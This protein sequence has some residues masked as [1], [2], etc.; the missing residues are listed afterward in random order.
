MK[1]DEDKSMSNTICKTIV[2]DLK[3]IYHMLGIDGQNT[4]KRVS[5]PGFWCD[6]KT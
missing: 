1:P 4:K 6:R 5:G 3:E 2:E